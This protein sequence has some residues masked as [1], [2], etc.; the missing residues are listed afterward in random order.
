MEPLYELIKSMSRNEKGYYK[1][2]ASAFG[3]SVYVLVF[4]EICKQENYEEEKILKKF[5]NQKFLKNFAVLKNY[6]FESITDSLAAFHS[7]NIAEIKMNKLISVLKILFDKTQNSAFEKHLKKTKEFAKKNNLNKH[8]LQVLKLEFD[9]LSMRQKDCIPLFEEEARLLQ[10]MSDYNSIMWVNNTLMNWVY[11]NEMIKSKKD[12]EEVYALIRESSLEK[13]EDKILP[14]NLDSYFTTLCL[15]YN[16][17]GDHEKALHYKIRQLENLEGKELKNPRKKLLIFGNILNLAFNAFNVSLFEKYFLQLEKIH[18]E[19]EGN[20]PLKTEQKL[21]WGVVYFLMREEYEKAV[22]F[23]DKNENLV[24]TQASK[25]S[26]AKLLSFFYYSSISGFLNDN[27]KEAKKWLYRMLQNENC[28]DIL[29]YYNYALLLE[30]VLLFESGE[31]E[32]AENKIR[33]AQR[34]FSKTHSADSFE[35]T[36]LNFITRQ[37]Q[38]PSEKNLT[39]IK[40]KLLAYEKT[41]YH[42]NSRGHFYYLKWVER[43]LF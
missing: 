27:F 37:I 26:T 21:I 17:W 8:M 24:L 43:K 25:M 19:C 42:Q 9:Y 40:E 20:K 10:L 12:E 34:Y 29:H 2:R 35:R 23:S 15:Y 30:I 1:K 18:A 7:K 38:K 36:F 6:L 28:K 33:S 4:D 22:A 3:D 11:K 41:P 39:A 31:E 14:E 16:T 5:A 32:L 13:R